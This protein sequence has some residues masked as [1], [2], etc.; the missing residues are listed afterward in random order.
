MP[1]AAKTAEPASDPLE[2]YRFRDELAHTHNPA[3]AHERMLVTHIAQAWLR[4][5][6]ARDTERRYFEGRDM[7][8]I[9]STKLN[10]FKAVTRFVADSER[11][12]RQAV[13]SLEQCQRRRKHES[14]FQ[15]NPRR[16]SGPPARPS[17]TPLPHTAFVTAPV[18]LKR[19]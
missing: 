14:L 4:L 19:E 8:E 11:S 12:W 7:V 3:N 16:G 17:E 10:E 6:L 15:P 2:L 18:E 9:I 5:Q 13:I 1:T